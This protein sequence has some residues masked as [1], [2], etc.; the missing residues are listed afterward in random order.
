MQT[1]K[2]I[3]IFGI[4]ILLFSCGATMKN[5]WS[6]EGY[7]GKH[8][9]KI[10]VIGVARNLESRSAFE[11]TTVRLLAENG[12]TAENSLTVLPPVKDMSEFSE[13]RI[14][15]IVRDGNYDAVLAATLIDVN[16]RDVVQSAGSY[17]GP[18]YAGRGYYGY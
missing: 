6:R 1:F 17:Y 2:K 18:M 12:I 5:T 8:F 10:L 13:E 15:K 4:T 3:G 7:T 11:N 16:T 9:D 14:V